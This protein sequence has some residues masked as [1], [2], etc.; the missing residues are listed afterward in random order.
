M[1]SV[2]PNHQN[3]PLLSRSER[4]SNNR[5]NSERLE[6]NPLEESTKKKSNVCNKCIIGFS[7]VGITGSGLILAAGLGAKFSALG[8]VGKAIVIS[9]GAL[10]GLVGSV[11]VPIVVGILGLSGFGFLIHYAI[12]KKKDNDMS[13]ALNDLHNPKNNTFINKNSKIASKILS[14]KMDTNKAAKILAD[15]RFD[16]VVAANI[17]LQMKQNG[18]NGILSEMEPNEAAC[19]LSEM[20]SSQ[21]LNFIETSNLCNWSSISNWFCDENKENATKLL[22]KSLNKNLSTKDRIES[23]S[24]VRDLSL[25]DHKKKFDINSTHDGISLTINHNLL[26]EKIEIKFPKNGQEL[27][28]MIETGYG[29]DSLESRI[30]SFK[31][32]IFRAD[33]NISL[34][35]NNYSFNVGDEIDPSFKTNVVEQI[36]INDFQK[37][38]IGILATQS[39]SIAMRGLKPEYASLGND[40]ESKFNITEFPSGDIKLDY[41]YKNKTPDFMKDVQNEMGLY[42]EVAYDASFFISK[43]SV[44]PLACNWSGS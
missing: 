20:E 4:V 43:D 29:K 23:F 8:V 39:L 19:I 37:K 25:S 26:Y 22:C 41:I 17:L 44:I 2:I 5:N 33:Y 27:M 34:Q 21:A 42:S 18:A 16:K 35:N 28:N 10:A 36:G 40:H 1:Q 38:N 11:A 13:N 31:K 9:S 24:K 12:N 7:S 3:S 30:E 6:Q 14:M 32:D 15:E